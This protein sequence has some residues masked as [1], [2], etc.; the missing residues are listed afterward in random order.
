MAASKILGEESLKG[1]GVGNMGTDTNS[2]DVT[3]IGAVTV[4]DTAAGEDA[5][6][7][8]G[9]ETGTGTGGGGG[10]IM[11]GNHRGE[12]VNGRGESTEEVEEG[13]R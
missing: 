10:R 5:G 13:S 3:V 2:G 9:L 1:G 8:A 11:G 6:T 4:A 12:K 7:E